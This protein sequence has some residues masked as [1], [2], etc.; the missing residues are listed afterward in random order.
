MTV[1][2]GNDR[3]KTRVA[4]ILTGFGV[5][6]Q[7]GVHNSS[8]QNLVRGVAERVL[9][10]SENGEL[11]PCRKPKAGVFVR[12]N[13]VKRR[14][15]ARLC[16]TTV[17]SRED[18]PALYSG[19][20]QAIYQRACESLKLVGIQRKD[21]YC[22][23]FVKAEK[24]NFSAKGDPAPRVIQP[25]T[26]R[27]NLEIGRYLKLF[28][29]EL[30]RG[31]VAVFGYP[32]IVKGFNADGVAAALHSNWTSFGDPVAIGLD[33]SRFD[34]HVSVEA[35]EFE[36]SLYNSVFRSPEL[37]QLL[38]WQLKNRG[39]GRIGDTC[40]KYQVDGC[41]MSG[42]IN[43]GMG[44]CLIMSCLVLNYFEE[45]GLQARLSNN[46]DDCVVICEKKDLHLL[47]GIESYFEEFGFKLK[48]EAPVEVFERIEFCQT[49]PVLVGDAYRM[50]RNPHTAMSKDCLSLL[51]MESEEQFETWRDAIGTCGLELTRGVPVWESFYRAINAGKSRKGGIERVYD[52]GMG[53][54]AR[55]VKQDCV[56]TDASRV[57]FYLAFG[58]T[59]TVQRIAEECWP[60]IVYTSK[61]PLRTLAEISQLT[62]NPL[63]CL[64]NATNN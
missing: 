13:S 3:G 19:R 41:R 61:P 50:V 5:G 17:V 11:R 12:L 20:K 56:V 10:V 22:S 44:N 2:G 4:H 53:Y 47:A 1:T 38:N 40:V 55:G 7:Y 25:R 26:P 48:R 39:Y 6:V 51:P 34:Q 15:L 37:A 35:L 28:E 62:I 27:Y 49:Q 29:K 36:H 63:R 33:A 23:T 9:F 18:Y 57:S 43:T 60:T 54:L 58:V 52:S 21:S 64:P 59:P 31:F 45:N 24:I 32:V 42:D 30:A 14:L 16:S 8:V 46:G